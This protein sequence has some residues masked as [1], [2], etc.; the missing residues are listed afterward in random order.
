MPN[1]KSDKKFK[2]T[3]TCTK[4]IVITSSNIIEIVIKALVDEKASIAVEGCSDSR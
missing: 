2:L 1:S 3:N 4:D